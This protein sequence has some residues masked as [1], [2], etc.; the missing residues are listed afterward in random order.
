MGVKLDPDFLTPD[1]EFMTPDR[2]F[3]TPDREFLMPNP[4]FVTPNPEFMASS[5]NFRSR[6]RQIS[7]FLLRPAPDFAIFP[8]IHQITP[9]LARSMRNYI[10]R[11]ASAA[12]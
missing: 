7:H 2:E 8:K 11:L 3:L 5:V 9:R 10:I 12:T 6:N 4:K 1:P